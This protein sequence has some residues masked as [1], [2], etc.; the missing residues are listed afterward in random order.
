MTGPNLTAGVAKLPAAVKVRGSGHGVADAGH[1][2][3][4]EGQVDDDGVG[5]RTKLL[6]LDKHHQDHHVA[7]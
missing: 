4:G 3:V 7:G 6:E 2:D 1:A 5:G